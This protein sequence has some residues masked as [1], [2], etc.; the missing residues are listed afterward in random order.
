MNTAGIQVA[1]R[2]LGRDLVA[3]RHLAVEM[4]RR[5]L[6]TEYRSSFLGALLAFI[7]PLVTAAWC[8][9]IQ[10]ARIIQDPKLD[11]PYPAFV[12]LSMMLWTTFIE[13]LNM[14]INRL[15]DELPMLARAAF[16]AEALVL[17]GMG[18]VIYHFGFKMILIVLAIWW[19]Q[20]PVT[21]TVVLA[22]LGVLS[23]I[24]LGTAL[25][26][27]LAP[28]NALVRDVSK[29]LTAVTTFWLFL[30]PVL[31]PPPTEGLAAKIVALNPVT[32]LLSAT[33]DWVVAGQA[34]NPWGF[35]GVALGAWV[36]LVLA[37]LWFRRAI[38]IVVDHSNC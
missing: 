13:S 35:V 20:L 3:S 27:F 15:I 8:T 16:P 6:L 21:G 11:L 1:L 4:L 32:P 7:P 31:F 25:G 36:L 29:T 18:E 2:E 30:T 28:L 22:P 26:V 23:L 33:R 12:L 37:L 19:Y 24:V 10:H 38:P 5:T 9:L 14:P 34:Q 17:A